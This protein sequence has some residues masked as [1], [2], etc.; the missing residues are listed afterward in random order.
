M[1][2]SKKGKQDC[3]SWE[4]LHDEVVGVVPVPDKELARKKEEATTRRVGRQDG[5]H[6][7][8]GSVDGVLG[9]L[10]W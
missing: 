6:H 5:S 1:D 2:D 7:G 4:H 9:C 8:K 10:R 3:A